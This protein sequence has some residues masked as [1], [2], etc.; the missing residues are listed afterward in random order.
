MK[1]FWCFVF[2]VLDDGKSA[3]THQL[4]V[5]CTGTSV[6]GAVLVFSLCDV[7]TLFFTRLQLVTTVFFSARIIEK[8][9]HRNATGT[10]MDQ[11]QL[12][13]TD[14]KMLDIFNPFFKTNQENR[15]PYTN[16]GYSR[17]GQWKTQF[18]VC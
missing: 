11:N 16:N 6:L 18:A 10:C 14:A 15:N 1:I 8:Q 13:C 4:P 12:S 17:Y 5:G 3:L 9:R 7:A 2:S